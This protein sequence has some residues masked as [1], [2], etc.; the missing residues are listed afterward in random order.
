[1]LTKVSHTSDFVVSTGPVLKV[2]AGGFTLDIHFL[3]QLLTDQFKLGHSLLYLVDLIQGSMCAAF[4]SIGLIQTDALLD[5][6]IYKTIQVAS[7]NS[8]CMPYP[9][10]WV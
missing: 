6:E 10:A 5:H 1:M 7:K 3:C 2:V 8:T 4:W 9:A